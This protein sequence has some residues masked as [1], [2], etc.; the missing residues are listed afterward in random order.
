[1]L[2]SYDRFPLRPF[3]FA[4]FDYV[5][6]VNEQ[7]IIQLCVSVEPSIE[8]CV[9]ISDRGIVG[10]HN[11]SV[12]LNVRRAVSVGSAVRVLSRQGLEMKREELL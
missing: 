2:R 3:R 10:P 5:L 7:G 12:G 9:K 1:M 11:W 8:L 6:Q 4:I